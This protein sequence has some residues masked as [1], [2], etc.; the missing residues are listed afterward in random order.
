MA[1]KY[2]VHMMYH[3]GK[4]VQRQSNAA[5]CLAEGTVCDRYSG[6][7]G[8]D[9]ALAVL[10]RG[11][12][13]ND[14]ASEYLVRAFQQWFQNNLPEHFPHFSYNIVICYW[15]KILN[16]FLTVKDDGTD[17]AVLFVYDGSYVFW[18]AGDFHVYEYRPQSAYLKRWPTNQERIELDRELGIAS[19]GGKQKNRDESISSNWYPEFRVRRI[20]ENT[21]FFICSNTICIKNPKMLENQRKFKK[22]FKKQ[23][24]KTGV[25][26]SLGVSG[27]E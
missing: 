5:V 25:T 20:S 26:V 19:V 1:D 17:A 2:R 8:S 3:A 22:C 23:S 13:K 15:Q 4:D 12:K 27:F 21:F 7:R 9:A 18:G 24:E 16:Q 11:D 6:H 14:A 10:C